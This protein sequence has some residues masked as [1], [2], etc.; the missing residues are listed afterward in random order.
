MALLGEG[1]EQRTVD[2]HDRIVA[3]GRFGGRGLGGARELSARRCRWWPPD[4]RSLG[5]SGFVCGALRKTVCV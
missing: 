5:A 3:D 4:G 1:G 2:L